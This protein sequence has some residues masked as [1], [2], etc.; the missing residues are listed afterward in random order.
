MTSIVLLCPASDAEAV[1]A[2]IAELGGGESNLSITLQDSN[3]NIWLGGHASSGLDFLVA[4][5]EQFPMLVVS[6]E[7]SGGYSH[8][9]A[10]LASNNLAMQ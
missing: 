5:T 8:W 10:A 4:I 1:N 2:T 9:Q 7:D 6:I 3:G